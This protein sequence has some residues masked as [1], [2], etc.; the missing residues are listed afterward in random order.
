[1]NLIIITIMII[2]LAIIIT[3]GASESRVE[4]GDPQSDTYCISDTHNPDTELR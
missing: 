1:M 2:T 4:A 3:F